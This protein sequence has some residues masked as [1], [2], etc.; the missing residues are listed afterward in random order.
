MLEKERKNLHEIAL[1]VPAEDF[2]DFVFELRHRSGMPLGSVHH[3]NV[4]KVVLVL[5]DLNR[6]QVDEGISVGMKVEV[7]PEI[8]P[9]A[10]TRLD[11]GHLRRDPLNKIGLLFIFFDVSYRLTVPRAGV[12]K[13]DERHV[14]RSRRPHGADSLI[15]DPLDD[16]Q[17]VLSG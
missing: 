17:V 15:V 7:R 2:F 12:A 13:G 3:D 16:R 1:H 9:S 10:E 14:L 5:V 8:V 6:R 4:G 11:S